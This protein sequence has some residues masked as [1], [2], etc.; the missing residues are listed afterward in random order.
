MGPK[1]QQNEAQDTD[2][3]KLAKIRPQIH[4]NFKDSTQIKCYFALC[5]IKNM[6]SHRSEQQYYMKP[7]VVWWFLW[8]MRR[9][10]LLSDG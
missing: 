2:L 5:S 9:Q 3:Y 7:T 6:T 4:V 1:L 8:V 10:D